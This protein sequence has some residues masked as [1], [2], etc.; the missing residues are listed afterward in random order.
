L[1][2]KLTVAARSARVLLR[3]MT[4]RRWLITVRRWRWLLILGWLFIHLLGLLLVGLR[5]GLLRSIR[6]WLRLRYIV[7]RLHVLH[8]LSGHVMHLMDRYLLYDM[9]P[10]RKRLTHGD[11]TSR[12]VVSAVLQ[13]HW[14]VGRCLGDVG[15]LARQRLLRLLRLMAG[16]AIR[17][18][19]QLLPCLLMRR[20]TDR[21][22]REKQN[23]GGDSE[24]GVG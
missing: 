5:R 24:H 4:V 7:I 17:V 19:L 3:L 22:R 8:R 11:T 15:E 12:L 20:R 6:R 21:G 23:S 1:P 14:V 2:G 9:V 10:L 13:R 16:R 18:L